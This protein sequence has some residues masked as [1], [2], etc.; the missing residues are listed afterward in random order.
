MPYA[1]RA[2]FG[3]PIIGAE[4]NYAYVGDIRSH[5]FKLRIDGKKNDFININTKNVNLDAQ[6]KTPGITLDLVCQPCHSANG[7]RLHGLPAAPAIAISQ[8]QDNATQ[9]HPDL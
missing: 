8:L 5:Q 1:G 6:G 3:Y 4:G 9:V 7:L 2:A